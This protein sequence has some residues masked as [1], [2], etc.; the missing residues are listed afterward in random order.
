MSA[1]NGDGQ[2]AAKLIDMK[3]YYI[4]ETGKLGLKAGHDAKEA[5][6]ASNEENVVYLW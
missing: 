2:S 4:D 1:A 6:D 5:R 3:G